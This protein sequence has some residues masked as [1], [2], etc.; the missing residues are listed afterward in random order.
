MSLFEKEYP[1]VVRSRTAII[2]VASLFLGLIL[3][4]VVININKSSHIDDNKKA[5]DVTKKEK[6]STAPLD[7]NWYKTKTVAPVIK[8][9]EK[10]TVLKASTQQNETHSSN[11]SEINVVKNPVITQDPEMEKILKAPISS[12]QITDNSVYSNVNNQTQSQAQS[13][14][15]LNG[16][17][18]IDQGTQNTQDQNLQNSKKAFLQDNQKANPDYLMQTL[19]SPISPYEVKAGTVIPATL[20]TGINSDLP[21]QIIGQVRNNVYDTVSGNYLLIPQGSKLTGL[22]DSQIVYGQSRV[23][24]VWQRII[25]P[26][27]QS[28]NLE[29]MPGIDLSGYAGFSDQVNNHNPTVNQMLAASLGTNIMNSSNAILQKSLGVQPTLVIRPGYLMNVSVTKDIVFPNVYR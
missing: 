24:V 4:I 23:L 19:K 7:S 13:N 17:R 28:I 5:Q 15:N 3:L 16:L 14:N 12:N 11:T 2:T 25:F 29:G 10:P 27:G 9:E 18:N 1:K 22:Y 26:N 8:Q 20:I 6:V 21:G